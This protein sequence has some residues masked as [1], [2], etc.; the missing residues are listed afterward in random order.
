MQQ[1]MGRPLGRD[2]PL[3]FRDVV[4]TWA[5]LPFRPRRIVSSFQLGNELNHCLAPSID[6]HPR[7]ISHTVAVR[8]H[9][10][11]VAASAR[12]RN[13]VV[14]LLVGD[15]HD[16]VVSLRS[17]PPPCQWPLPSRLRHEAGTY[18]ARRAT[19]FHD[20]PARA[21]PRS[22]R[23]KSLPS[24]RSREAESPVRMPHPCDASQ[25]D[26]RSQPPSIRRRQPATPCGP[27][28]EPRG[29][30]AR[31]TSPPPAP[32]PTAE[33]YAQ[34]PENETAKPDQSSPLRVPQHQFFVHTCHLQ[35]A[36]VAKQ[37]QR[38]K[39]ALREQTLPYLALVCIARLASGSRKRNLPGVR[40]SSSLAARRFHKAA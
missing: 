26:A 22:R 28:S 6:M 34:P 17:R 39:L 37:S 23:C 5:V 30:Q 20:A 32:V 13:L 14:R 36:Q 25:S 40:R 24:L 38:A 4:P 29:P 27:A 35:V 11:H 18:P 7:A 15:H 19:P 31:E 33:R 2:S 3:V 10:D 1:K 8:S 9:V 16:T 21:L 12:C